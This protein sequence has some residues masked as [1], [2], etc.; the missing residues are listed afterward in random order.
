MQSSFVFHYCYHTKKLSSKTR[1]QEYNLTYKRLFDCTGN[2]LGY[3]PKLS[4]GLSLV[5]GAHFQYIFLGKFPLHDTFS[6]DE[7]S[8]SEL[9]NL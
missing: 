9:F 7:I 6:I 2:I 1:I 5:F 4:K 3:S 8:L